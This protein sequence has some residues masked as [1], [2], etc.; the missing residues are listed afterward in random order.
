[1]ETGQ[2]FNVQ[3]FSVHDGPGVR[4]TI[5]LKGCP[6]RCLWCHNPES[7][8]ASPRVV[9]LAERCLSC[10]GCERVCP[11]ELEPAR[12]TVCGACVD[13][14]PSEA[15]QL[16]GR[17]ATVAEVLDEVAADRVFYEESH[18]GITVSGG[19]PLSQPV[20]L[21]ALLTGA[22][23]SRLATAVDT[24]GA[25]ALSSLLEIA[26]LVDLFLYDIKIMDAAR[27]LAY[28][29][30]PLAPV[31]ANLEAL[32]AVH[33]NIWIRIPIVP[34][35]TDDERCLEETARLAA[36]VPGVRR[37]HLLPYHRTGAGKFERL[38]EVCPVDGVVPPSAERMRALAELFTARSLD[39]RIGG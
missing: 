16:V 33:R 10:G 34:G 11:N 20:F 14:C 26:P 37:V 17:T 38:G 18:G 25:G 5:F 24:C 19:E 12:C 39:T 15:R 6:A 32:G 31:V 7:Q 21:R 4:T 35:Y 8:S 29:G 30:L 9:K 36:S 3:R 22:R 27:H 28:T 13:A 1:M 2:I 23:A